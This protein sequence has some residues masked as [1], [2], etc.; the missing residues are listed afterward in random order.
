MITNYH[1][2]T[3]WLCTWWES[4]LPWKAYSS[5]HD[6]SHT[7]HGKCIPVYMM[8][9]IL[10]MESVFQCAYDET[11]TSHFRRGF[12]LYFR[13]CCQIWEIVIHWP[14]L[15]K[16]CWGHVESSLPWKLQEKQL[17]LELY[18]WS[19]VFCSKNII[20]SDHLAYIFNE[21]NTFTLSLLN[22]Y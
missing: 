5:V 8:R 9:V 14:Q 18:F 19:E 22:K 3:P 16:K 20:L 7:C 12:F 10:A 15:Y 2:L 4:Y 21:N 17:E 13:W 11:S 1:K 6:E